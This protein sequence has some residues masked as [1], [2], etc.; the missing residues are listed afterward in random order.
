[1]LETLYEIR[2]NITEQ[3][4]S[5]DTLGITP[6]ECILRELES[7]NRQIDILRDAMSNT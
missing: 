1:M 6:N 7:I 5:W 4:D 3:I 2:R